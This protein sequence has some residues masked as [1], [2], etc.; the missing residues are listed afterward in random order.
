[1]PAGLEIYEDG[2]GRLKVSFGD[3][4]L[5]FLGDPL[6]V[7]EGASGSLVNNGFLTGTPVWLAA[8]FDP[9][10]SGYWP[11]DRLIPPLVSISGNTL[12]YTVQA[13]LG[14]QIIHYGVY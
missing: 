3:R 1:M 12:S 14:T 9:G 11:G 7:G 13:G 6:I 5:R 10:G 8:P 2:T 4:L